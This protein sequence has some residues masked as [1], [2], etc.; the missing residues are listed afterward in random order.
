MSDFQQKIIRHI[1]R[2]KIYFQ[3]TEKASN[4]AERDV[5]IM[6][7]GIWS[8]YDQYIKGFSRKS[9]LYARTDG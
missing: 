9:W 2:L 3:D 5:E 6:R 7:L 4:M 1:K 8:S